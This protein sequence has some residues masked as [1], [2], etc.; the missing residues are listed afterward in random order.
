MSRSTKQIEFGEGNH[1]KF[2]ASGNISSGILVTLVD[3]KAKKAH[4]SDSALGVNVMPV[5]EGNEAWI[6]LN[7]VA[8]VKITGADAE[9]HMAIRATN[10]LAMPVA[11]DASSNPGLTFGYIVADTSNGSKGLIK[12]TL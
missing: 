12:L 1:W 5:S 9:D 4:Y 3:G 2:I 7:G 6:M 11:W 10:G 8:Q